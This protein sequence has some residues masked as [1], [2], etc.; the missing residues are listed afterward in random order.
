MHNFPQVIK[1]SNQLSRKAFMWRCQTLSLKAVSI[2]VFCLATLVITMFA[3]SQGSLSTLMAYLIF[4]LFGFAFARVAGKAGVPLFRLVFGISVLS[5]VVLYLIYSSRYGLPYFIGG[6]DDLS[7]E[8]DAEIIAKNLWLY[9]AEEIGWLINI[10]YH[11]S[12]GYIYLVSLLVRFGDSLGG[13]HTMI[14]RLFNCSMLSLASVVT[15]SIS[16]QI[17]LLPYPAKLAALWVGLFP[18]MVY[19]A[20]HTFRDI[21]IALLLLI[22]AK[23]ALAISGSRQWLVPVL[24]SAVIVSLFFVMGELRFFYLIAMAAM[25]ATAWFAKLWPEKRFRIA[26][27]LILIIPVVITGYL[28]LS[29]ELK[30]LL[31][32][33]SAIDRYGVSLAGGRGSEDGLAARLFSLPPPW[34]Y[35]GRFTYALVTPLPILYSNIE[36]NLLGAGAMAQFFF[37]AFVLLGIKE[38]CRNIWLL[39]MLFGFA[40]LFFG[41]T[42]GTFTFRHITA[43]VPF[44]AIYGVIG[45]SKFR[46]YRA[47]IFGMCAFLLVWAGTAYVYL[48][49]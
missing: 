22:T 17:G 23:L 5:A 31:D 40:I 24:L 9:N 12:K 27:I 2:V 1:V 4:G 11:N 39:P 41:Y 28:L 26:S 37:A 20:I 6:S 29:I 42:M 15:Y 45:Y 46:H 16:R 13:F 19:S 14:P 34:I 49:I 21:P 48:K 38:T 35:I 8:L 18:M 7:Y 10:P 30:I 25:L 44:A 43:F 32:S 47:F 36:W 3:L 33:L